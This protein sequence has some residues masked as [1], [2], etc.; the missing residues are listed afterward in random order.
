MNPYMN[1]HMMNL[2]GA[3][4]T[5]P[6]PQGYHDVDRSTKVDWTDARLAKITRLR[7]VSDP[8][9]PLWDISY[10]HGV[11]KD[12]TPCRV[13]LPFSQLPK[14][15]WMCHILDCARQD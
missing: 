3:I 11:L 2:Y 8:G 13:M 12:G 7:M 1:P 10:C 15:T 9:F 5:N 4:E 14:R 6:I